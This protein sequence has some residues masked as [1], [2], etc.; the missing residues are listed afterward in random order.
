VRNPNFDSTQ[1][2]VRAAILH[3]LQVGNARARLHGATPA[4]LGAALQGAV[5]SGDR[6]TE[7]VVRDLTIAHVRTVGADWKEP[8]GVVA[9][10]DWPS[11][12]WQDRHVGQHAG[13]LP[14]VA[15][16]RLVNSLAAL[17]H[18]RFNADEAEALSAQRTGQAPGALPMGELF[19]VAIS[20]FGSDIAARQAVPAELQPPVHPDR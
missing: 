18:S 14:D 19:R 7:S 17:E 2:D 12:D 8:G 20:V 10:G 9:P 13:Q 5:E 16:V 3:E 1:N 6:A 4:E 11:V 15:L